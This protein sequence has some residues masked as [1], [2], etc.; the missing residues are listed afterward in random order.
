MKTFFAEN[1]NQL[2]KIL[3]MLYHEFSIVTVNPSL[4]S[5]YKMIFEILVDMNEETFD[6]YKRRL[7]TI[8]SE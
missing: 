2:G 7:A 3:R 1:D 5:D 6:F 4:N 8:Y